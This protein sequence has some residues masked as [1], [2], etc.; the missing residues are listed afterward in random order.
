[1]RLSSILKGTHKGQV[2][3]V[4]LIA[5]GF[6]VAIAIVFIA[7][8][9]QQFSTSSAWQTQVVA[10]SATAAIATTNATTA[11]FTIGDFFA[12]VWIL[13]AIAS[14][15]ATFFIETS[16]VFAL[17]GIIAM[18]IEIFFSLLF[19][20]FFFIMA[21]NSFLA[22]TIAQL[23]FLVNFFTG[24]PSIAII[25]IFVSIILTFSGRR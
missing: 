5:Y 13:S 17:L 3:V 22:P 4:Y 19:H 21:Q 24:L 10:K 11:I 6:C 18:P 2:D 12:A 7:T 15:I 20:D 16:P 14:V 8:F 1:M 9:W 25:L 23:P